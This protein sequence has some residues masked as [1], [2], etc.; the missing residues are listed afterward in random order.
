MNF[1]SKSVVYSGGIR[2]MLDISFIPSSS[3][4]RFEGIGILSRGYDTMI[5]RALIIIQSF[6]TEKLENMVIAR[7]EATRLVTV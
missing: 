5:S 3:M 2:F 6:W 1:A 7:L 4:N